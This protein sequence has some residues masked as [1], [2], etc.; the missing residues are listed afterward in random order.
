VHADHPAALADLEHQGV[1]GDEGVRPLVEGAV[2]EVGDLGV[3]VLGHLADLG[4]AQ[5]RNSERLHQLLHPP[6]AD[7]EQVAGG[8]HGGQ[9]PLRPAAAFQQPVGEVAAGA[10]LGDRHVQGAGAGIELPRPI[11]VA[12]VG[13][14]GGAGAV[15][16]AADRVGLGGHQRVD[17]GGEH[18][19]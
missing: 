2:A 1:G 9:R 11:P 4:L 3:E 12:D 19:P 8:H 10:E 15:L 6:G 18:L 14:L 5:P 7:P 17:E 16:G 13:P